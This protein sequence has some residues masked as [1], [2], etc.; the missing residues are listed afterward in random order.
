MG[1][2]V[3]T[4]QAKVLVQ[5]IKKHNLVE[6]TAET[7]AYLYGKLESLQKKFPKHIQSLRG[8]DKGTF[9]AWDLPSGANRDAF[10]MAMKQN[11]VLCGGSG[12]AAVRLR[13][14]LT[15]TNHHADIL[16]EAVE[17]TAAG[18]SL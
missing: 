2:P 1:D 4:L 17:K 5:E 18:M 9:I 14:T 3:R 6:K 10:L 11:G 7:G 16:L 13:P 15:F 8:K 12:A